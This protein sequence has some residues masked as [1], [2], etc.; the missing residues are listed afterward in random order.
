MA[1]TCD[2]LLVFSPEHRR[3]YIS[4]LRQFGRQADANIALTPDGGGE[5]LLGRLGRDTGEVA[6]GR[7]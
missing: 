2:A 4:T 5:P 3:L 1:L 7:P 6:R